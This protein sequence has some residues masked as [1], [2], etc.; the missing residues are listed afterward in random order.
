[1]SSL[2]SAEEATGKAQ[3]PFSGAQ[4]KRFGPWAAEGG[5]GPLS[6]FSPTRH[7]AHALGPPREPAAAGPSA[8]RGRCVLG[9]QS[10]H[11]TVRCPGFNIYFLRLKILKGPLRE[12]MVLGLHLIRKEKPSKA[13]EQESGKV[14]V[15]WEANRTK[16]E[17]REIRSRGQGLLRAGFKWSPSAPL[18]PTP[19]IS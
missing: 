11:Q 4:V 9:H 14:C 12:A 17:R 16:A 5:G 18:P 7:S 6:P 10:R 13:F 19:C 2:H 8:T 1:M 3:G 15:L